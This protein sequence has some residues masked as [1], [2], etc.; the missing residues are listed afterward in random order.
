MFFD[1]TVGQCK[2]QPCQYFGPTNE[3]Y[4]MDSDTFK[5]KI[6]EI[7]NFPRGWRDEV[8]RSD[9]CFLHI[10]FNIVPK[11]IRIAAFL[12]IIK[13]GHFQCGRLPLLPPV[14]DSWDGNEVADWL[15]SAGIVG[16]SRR[17]SISKNLNGRRFRQGLVHDVLTEYEIGKV[18][19]DLYDR[20]SGFHS[21][22]WEFFPPSHA[23][24]SAVCR[25][26]NI[27]FEQDVMVSLE[28]KFK[29][30][31]SF[32]LPVPRPEK[33]IED[34]QL[35]F[36]QN[37]LRKED[38]G[39]SFI[40]HIVNLCDKSHELFA[41]YTSIEQ[42]RGMGKSRLIYESWEN[43][44]HALF[45]FRISCTKSEE[46]GD[47]GI[48]TGKLVR[49]ILQL[50][51]QEQ[52]SQLLWSLLNLVLIRSLDDNGFLKDNR[53]LSQSMENLDIPLGRSPAFIIISAATRLARAS[54]MQ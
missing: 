43:D 40:G 18:N 3:L 16:E 8:G 52:M 2:C 5:K 47:N 13:L 28:C 31:H 19:R 51:S 17:S 14:Q 10:V 9:L 50:R 23:G 20:P 54:T 25:F 11:G 36:H 15:I 44:D 53:N 7:P 21:D 46:L 27:N 41:C 45:I 39:K 22:I 34:V 49:F 38:I 32:I 26:F 29:Q 48:E 12:D 1:T 42:G 24:H 33:Q 37:Y 4:Q 6:L 35:A 30:M